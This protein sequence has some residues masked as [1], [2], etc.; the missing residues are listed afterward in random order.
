MKDQGSLGI[1]VLKLK[2]EC[3]LSKWLFKLLSQEGMWQH[4]LHNKY[5]HNKTLS[6]VEDKSVDS[7]F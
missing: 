1:E 6:Q 7:T 4:L 3:M 2:N 5:L